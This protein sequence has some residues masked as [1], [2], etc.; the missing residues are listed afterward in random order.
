[1]ENLYLRE[2]VEYHKALGFD[3]IVLYDNNLPDGERPEEV[4]GDYVRSGYVLLRDYRGRTCCQNRAYRHAYTRWASRYDWV[5][6]FDVDEYLTFADKSSVQEWLDQPKFR[7]FTSVV[8]NWMCYSDNGIVEF[9]RE[10]DCSCLNRFTMPVMPIDFK[11][12]YPDIP[13]NNHVKSFLRGGMFR[14]IVTKITNPHFAKILGG[15]YC[16]ACGN[17][18]PGPS[19]FSPMN[20]EEAWM[21]HFATKTIHE[22]INKIRRGDATK[23]LEEAEKLRWAK[24]FFAYNEVTEEKVR[25]MED[26]LGYDLSDILSEGYQP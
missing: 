10:G 26:A 12:N 11:R 19:P 24:G 1:M 3:R 9:S 18:L 14:P 8:V 5:A 17:R 16:D 15:K 4:I 6:F 22:Y 23:I 7:G 20:Y 13:E 21:R 25:I 2:W